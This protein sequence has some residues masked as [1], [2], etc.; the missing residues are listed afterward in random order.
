MPPV[1]DGILWLEGIWKTGVIW[2]PGKR[3]VLILRERGVVFKRIIRRDG[4][5]S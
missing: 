2:H 3:Y 1:D 4:F 5:E